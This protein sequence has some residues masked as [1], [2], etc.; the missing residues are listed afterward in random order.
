M[1]CGDAAVQIHN[2]EQHSARSTSHTQLSTLLG[3]KHWHVVQVP[4]VNAPAALIHWTLLQTHGPCAYTQR[5]ANTH[6][7]FYKHT[8]SCICIYTVASHHFISL[9][10]YHI[11]LLYL[12]TL[13]LRGV[14]EESHSWRSMSWY[15]AKSKPY[16]KLIKKKTLWDWRKNEKWNSGWK[17]QIWNIWNIKLKGYWSK[18]QVFQV[19]IIE[20]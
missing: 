20:K 11:L 4:Q 18:T 5:Q 16:I 14:W 8:Y 15:T 9:Q 19:Q 10:K 7:P 13:C 17:P 6:A 1:T 2:Q 3:H 12:V